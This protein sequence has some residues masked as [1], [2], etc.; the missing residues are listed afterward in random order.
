MIFGAAFRRRYICAEPPASTQEPTMTDRHERQVAGG[1][2][3]R[4]RQAIDAYGSANS[5]AKAIGR[6]EGA[7]R[8]WLRG[9]SEPNVTDLRTLCEQTH[10]SIEW[11]VTGHGRR[12]AVHT[13]ETPPPSYENQP[14]RPPLNY[15]LLEAIMDAID[16]EVS[17]DALDLPSPK[18]SMLVVTLY[19]L[20]QESQKVD[21]DAVAR[22]VKLAR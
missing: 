18:R 8:K 3:G 7:V 9:E 11:L 12:E 2:A 4:L 6:S 22:L 1:F 21:N 20:F 14:N 15:A 17:K 16:V 5:I 19:D 13:L 10:T